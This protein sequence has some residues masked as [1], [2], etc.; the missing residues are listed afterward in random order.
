[1]NLLLTYEDKLD[2]AIASS[3]STVNDA[4]GM[5]VSQICLTLPDVKQLLPLQKRVVHQDVYVNSQTKR[6]QLL[7]SVTVKKHVEN[8]PIIGVL[9]RF[10]RTDYS[11]FLSYDRIAVEVAKELGIKTK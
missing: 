7:P 5:S 4:I 10:L 9:F 11:D 6:Y 2:K 1:M 8:C 3:Q